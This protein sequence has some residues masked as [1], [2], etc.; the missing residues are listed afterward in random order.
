[1]Y[2]YVKITALL[3][4][5][6]MLISCKSQITKQELTIQVENNQNFSRNEIVEIS[7]KKLSELLKIHIRKISR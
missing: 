4:M 5:I 1:M 7:Y 2:K 6:G 3:L